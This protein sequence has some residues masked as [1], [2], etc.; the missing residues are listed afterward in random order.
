MRLNKLTTAISVATVATAFNALG[1]VNPAIAI[2]I[3]G[4]DTQNNLVFFDS[5]APST[6]TGTVA[7]S[8]LQTNEVLQGIDYRPA[9]NQL[10]GIGSTSQVYLINQFTGAASQVGS[11]FSP[12]LAGSTFGVDFNPVPD[13]IRVVSNAN[14]NLRIN[15]SNGVALTDG[16]LAYAATDANTD[17]PANIAAV[18][19]TN[20]VA[21]ATSTTLYGIDTALDILVIQ[22]PPNAG[23]LNTVGDLG[24]NFSNLAGFD[25]FTSQGVNTAFASSGSSLFGIN[26]GTGAATSLGVI[27]NGTNLRDISVTAVP[28]PATIVGTLVGGSVLGMLRRRRAKSAN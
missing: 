14:Q 19:Y 1:V 5:I 18:A 26:L 8:G 9:T 16:N 6:I 20:N 4:L 25:I 28:E 11:P 21:G 7:V 27:G 17:Q 23:T 3:T 12:S 22:N 15:P 10:Y 13:R 2:G 24:V